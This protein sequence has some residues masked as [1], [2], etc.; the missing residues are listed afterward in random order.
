[1]YYLTSP[2]CFGVISHF[3]EYHLF[4]EDDPKKSWIFCSKQES[5]MA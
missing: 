2:E 1:M 3:Q 4:V 5:K